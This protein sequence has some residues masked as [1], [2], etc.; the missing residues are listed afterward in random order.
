MGISDTFFYDTWCCIQLIVFT[1]LSTVDSP[2][3][4]ILGIQLVLKTNSHT[5]VYLCGQQL[6]LCVQQLSTADSPVWFILDINSVGFKNQMYTFFLEIFNSFILVLTTFCLTF[7]LP[8][9]ILYADALYAPRLHIPDKTPRV[10]AWSRKLLDK[11][12]S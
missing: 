3:R 4:F 10:A 12:S 7:F 6:N 5:H 11:L 8:T 2:I 1:Q 9:Q